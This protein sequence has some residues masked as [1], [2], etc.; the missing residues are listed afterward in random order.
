MIKTFMKPMVFLALLAF[1]VVAHADVWTGAGDGTSYE[2]AFNWDPSTNAFPGSTRDINGAFTVTRDVDVTVDRT[3]V[4]GGA[5]LNVTAGSHN[6]SQPGNSIRNFVGN[7][8]VGTVNMS[9]ASTYWGIGHCLGIAHSSNSDGTFNLTGG[10]LNVSRGSANSLVGGYGGNFTLGHAISIGGNISNTG[11]TGLM[12]ISGGLLKTRTGIAV[13]KN[14]TFSIVGSG[15]STILLG[16]SGDEAGWFALSADGLLKVA[17]DAGGVTK[18]FVEDKTNTST[19]NPFAEFQAGSLLY[20]TNTTSYGG[21]WTLLEV[22]NGAITDNG[23]ALAPGVDT[24]IWSFAIDNS[25]ANGKLTITAQ[26]DPA[27]VQ[28]DVTLTV[29]DTKKQ[30]MRYGLDYERLWYWY[31]SGLGDVPQWSVNDCNIDYIR[32][33]MNSGYELTEGTYD[34]SAYTSKI[35][36]MMTA[37]QNANPN[38]KWFA[39]PRP[40][41]EAV[42]GASWQPYPL[43][44]TGAT[45]YTSGDYDFNATKCAEYMIRYLLLMKSYGFKITY[46]DLTNEWQSDFASGGRLAPDDAVAIKQVFDDYLA[47]PWPHPALD[48]SLLLEADDFPLMV[49]PSSWNYS[50]GSSWISRFTTTARRDAIDIASSHNTDKTGTA[51]QFADAAKAALGDDV[52]IWETEQ[53]G[54][55]GNST[56]SEAMSFSYMIETVRAGF[57]GLSGWL[58]IG[59]TAQGHCYLLNNGTTV[60]RNVKYY[61]FKKLSNTSNYGYALDINETTDLSSTMALVRDNL[62]TVWIINTASAGVITEIDFSGH[63][64]D[65]SDITVTRWDEDL[66]IDADE[67]PEGIGEDAVL[68]TSSNVV[69]DLAGRAAYCIEIPLVNNEDNVPFVQAESYDAGS[70]VII[71]PCSDAGAGDMVVFLSAGAEASYDLDIVKTYPHDVAFRVSSES[72]NIAFDIYDGTNL[73]ASVNRVATGDAQNWTTIYKTLPLDGGPMDLRIVA[74]GGD[75]N[76]NWINFDQQFYQP[77]STLENLALGQTY[78][79]SNV[80]SAG[81]EADKAFDGNTGTRW[82]SAVPTPWL[83][84]DFGTPTSVNGSMILDYGNRTKGYEIQYYDGSWKTAFIGGDPDDAGQVDSFP[85]VT[86]T[87]FRLQVTS[88]SGSPSIYEF[89]LY[90]TPYPVVSMSIDSGSVSLSW[91]GVEGATY[92]L[93]RSTNLVTDAFSTTIESGIPVHEATNVNV[94]AIPDESAFYR[95][96]LE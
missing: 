76:M 9:G 37:M 36:P 34:L 64:W 38:I 62:L 16:G 79:A 19:I 72:A 91:S 87:K 55:K 82:A 7:G 88:S 53:H 78:D 14:G 2:D 77:D 95:V 94:M 26:G 28:P 20:L 66:S 43:W 32:C 65:G 70:S 63:T 30:M 80:H 92:A 83:E 11:V 89:E 84:V 93:Q 23:L 68:A 61:M 39:S 12:E 44:V 75:W 35:I 17:A 86:G 29:G 73:L 10:E 4:Q 71:A 57:T 56:T 69:V 21:T 6:D 67:T 1:C 5:T 54:W 24:D 31:G 59:T 60:K 41:D 3:F 40:L 51:Q 81:Y 45:T 18:I 22:E 15:A 46:M 90:Y 27:P 96:I 48:P 13:A 50:Q 52:E 58:A 49:G 47:N 33:A 8:S 42:S 25:G 85:I 74:T